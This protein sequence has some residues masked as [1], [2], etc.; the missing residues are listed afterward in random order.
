M[1]SWLERGTMRVKWQV[2]SVHSLL[3][4]CYLA[5]D[6]MLSSPLGVEANNGYVGDYPIQ[7][8][9]LNIYPHLWQIFNIFFI[10]VSIFIFFVD[11]WALLYAQ[12]MALKQQAPLIVC[13]CLPSKYLEAT[14]RQYSFM[15]KGL[16]EVEKVCCSCC[17]CCL[18]WYPQ[19]Y[20]QYL[21]LVD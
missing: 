21:A 12:R 16:Q 15:I 6:A 19:K 3:C 13:F 11:N 8:S 5:C 7:G 17:C 14:F 2:P 20:W 1:Y 9:N 18:I 4:R 10:T